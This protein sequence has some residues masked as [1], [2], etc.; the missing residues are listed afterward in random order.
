MK[1]GLPVVLVLFA[2][3]ACSVGPRRG[4]EDPSYFPMAADRV[5]EYRLR[6]FPT[7]EVWPVIVHSRGAKFVPALGRMAVIFDE[8]YPDQVVPIAF[9]LSGGFLQ[10]EIGLRYRI[11]R[12][13]ELMPLGTQ[14]M[15]VMPMPP[16]VGMSWAYFEQVFGSSPDATGFEIRWNG[17][18]ARAESVTVPAGVFRGCLRI[19]SIALHRLPMDDRPREYRYLDWYAPNI[20]LVKSEYASGGGGE[21]FTRMEL[22]SFLRDSRPPNPSIPAPA[23]DQQWAFELGE[24]NS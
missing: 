10:S 5:W 6:N 11:E 2:A 1:Y 18:I 15:R 12:G 13:M 21:T 24:L 23:G 14:P 8:Q 20:G 17:S 19:E 7:D 3:T 22:V 9:F 16:R 4:G